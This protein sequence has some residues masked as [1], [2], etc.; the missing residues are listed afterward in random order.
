M[1][2]K[3]KSKIIQD[4]DL[5][6]L[7]IPSKEILY[8]EGLACNVGYRDERG[9][10]WK[11]FQEIYKIEKQ[12]ISEAKKTS[13]NE[14]EFEITLSESEGQDILFLPSFETGIDSITTALSALGCAPVSSCRS[15]PYLDKK[16]HVPY[17]AAWSTKHEAEK[18]L[19][20]AKGLEIAVRNYEIEGYEG[21]I[22]Y[23]NDLITLLNFSKKLYD[24][25]KN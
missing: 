18:I 25:H 1:I 10:G 22:V 17:A 23:S 15:H 19:A 24:D 7:T 14:T 13:N 9:W 6:I 16:T 20:S 21:L 5:S 2:P 11:E 8:A 4:L 12:I 3:Y